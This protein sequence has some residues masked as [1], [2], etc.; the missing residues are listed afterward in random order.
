MTDQELLG[1]AAK[2]L[3]GAQL[4]IQQTE[5][6]L[7]EAMVQI[8][9]LRKERD[10][11]CALYARAEQQLDGANKESQNVIKQRDDARRERDSLYA[12][13]AK[14]EQQCSILIQERDNA[15]RQRDELNKECVRMDGIWR[16]ER[17][18]CEK[19]AEDRD[20]CARMLE[21]GT[22]IP[23]SVT[24]ALK[25]NKYLLND[26]C[27]LASAYDKTP[28]MIVANTL[29]T[30]QANIL[31]ARKDTGIDERTQAT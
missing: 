27:D 29:R 30:L 24:Q 18:R 12:S 10:K 17:L 1:E 28:N 13:Y 9:E 3:A 21:L 6:K 2:R 8:A 31:Q 26:A 11:F 23:E 16:E 5:A 19:I 4:Y 15:V 20:R 14:A 22:P 7:A 25:V